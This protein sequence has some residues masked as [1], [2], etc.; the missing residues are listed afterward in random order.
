MSHLKMDE[1][2]QGGDVPIETYM[3][4]AKDMLLLAGIV[5]D[6]FLQYM[7]SIVLNMT[8]YTLNIHACF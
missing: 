5:Q 7:N 6:V 3:S 1:L 8:Q 4:H 2:S